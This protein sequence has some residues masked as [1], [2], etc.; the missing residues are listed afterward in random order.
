VL[1]SRLRAHPI[2]HVRP[3]DART[4]AW[5]GPHGDAPRGARLPEAL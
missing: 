3:G 1:G 5:S 4:A 2:E